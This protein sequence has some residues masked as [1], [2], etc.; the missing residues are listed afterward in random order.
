[1]E[2]LDTESFHDTSIFTWDSANLLLVFFTKKIYKKTSSKYGQYNEKVE[3]I[4]L[5]S[6]F[7][8]I[9]QD[10]K[11]SLRV[12]DWPLKRQKNIIIMKK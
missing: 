11:I 8:L 9:Y 10:I 1:M 6:V 7:F 3:I 12:I 2:L 4:L 5:L